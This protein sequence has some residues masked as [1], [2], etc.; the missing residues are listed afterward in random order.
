MDKEKLVELTRH[1][2][3]LKKEKKDY[4]KH[5]NESIKNVEAEIKSCVKE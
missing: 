1:V 2:L 5:M 3:D 4:N